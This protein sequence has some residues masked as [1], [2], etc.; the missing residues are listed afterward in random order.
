MQRKPAKPLDL[1]PRP[2]T[3]EEWEALLESEGLGEIDNLSS[4]RD[5]RVFCQDFDVKSPDD[6]YEPPTRF[7]ETSAIDFT[8]TDRFEAWYQL[9]HLACALSTSYQ[10]R[11]FLIDWTRTGYMVESAN[12][13]NIDKATA[14]AAIRKFLKRTGRINPNDKSRT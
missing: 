5:N 4:H 13:Y 7:T 1:D 2:A 11:A 8:G 6:C 10:Y 12:K 9:E 3:P 14:V